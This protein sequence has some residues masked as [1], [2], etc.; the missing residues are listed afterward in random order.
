MGIRIVKTGMLAG[1]LMLALPLFAAAMD[2]KG[3][4][5][6]QARKEVREVQREAEKKGK[7]STMPRT[8][9]FRKSGMISRAPAMPT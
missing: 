1:A 5:T 9:S 6:E 7:P 8:A 4:T 3:T 2:D